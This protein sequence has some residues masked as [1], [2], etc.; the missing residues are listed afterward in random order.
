MSKFADFDAMVLE[1]VR[2]RPLNF[3]QL[4]KRDIM[5]AAKALGDQDY[6][7]LDRRLQ[8]LRKAGKIRFHGGMWH[9]VTAQV[10]A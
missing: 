4:Q 9:F 1:E 7:V 6:R 2:Q 3:T 8:A 10:S 5:T